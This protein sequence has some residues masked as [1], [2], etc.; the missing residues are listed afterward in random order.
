MSSRHRQ[1]A[2]DATHTRKCPRIAVAGSRIFPATSTKHV[3]ADASMLPPP[4]PL[5][6]IGVPFCTMSLGLA[7]RCGRA[8]EKMAAAGRTRPVM[9]GR[10]CVR[11]CVMG[12]KGRGIGHLGWLLALRHGRLRRFVM[13]ACPDAAAIKNGRDAVCSI[14]IRFLRVVVVLVP[15]TLLRPAFLAGV[16]SVASCRSVHLISC[17][18]PA[19]KEKK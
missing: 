14:A 11:V 13:G 9:V 4:L 7:N 3:A 17:C 15:R 8:G 19:K 12:G 5:A 2:F 1:C 10:L 18:A 6:V 16:L